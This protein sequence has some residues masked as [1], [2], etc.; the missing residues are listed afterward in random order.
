MKKPRKT[1]RLVLSVSIGGIR[2]L[3]LRKEDM[4]LLLPA[5]RL[6][7]RLLATAD[8][9]PEERWLVLARKGKPGCGLL[10][11]TQSFELAYERIRRGEQPPLLPSERRT[12]D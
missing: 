11:D 12:K 4:L 6:I 1:K 9:P 7:Q 10:V 2:P 5:P 3:A 8:L